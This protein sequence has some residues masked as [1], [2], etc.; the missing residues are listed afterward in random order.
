MYEKNKYKENKKVA[1]DDNILITMEKNR[2]VGSIL[3]DCT[4]CM[5][6]YYPV[7]SLLL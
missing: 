2:L 4:K 7:T 1:V 5:S 3:D 6:F